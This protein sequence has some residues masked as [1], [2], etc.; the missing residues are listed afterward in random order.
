MPSPPLFFLLVSNA[1]PD[2]GSIGWI[3]KEKVKKRSQEVSVK[4]APVQDD[5]KS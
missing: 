5:V 2:I 1:F 4:E 3:E